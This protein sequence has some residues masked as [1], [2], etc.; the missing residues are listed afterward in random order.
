[1]FDFNSKISENRVKKVANPSGPTSRVV[2]VN[3]VNPVL[4]CVGAKYRRRV[5]NLDYVPTA[6]VVY[7]FEFWYRVILYFLIL[8]KFNTRCLPCKKW[9]RIFLKIHQKVNISNSLFQSLSKNVAIH[10]IFVVYTAFM[11]KFTTQ[12]Q[13]QYYFILFPCTSSHYKKYCG[14]KILIFSEIRYKQT[15]HNFR[16]KLF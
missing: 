5:Q 3:T 12:M 1:M 8:I 10:S 13:G 6:L 4:L 16:G 7:I 9:L 2:A 15:C 11:R 14:I